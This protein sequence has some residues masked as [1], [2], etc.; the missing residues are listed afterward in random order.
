VDKVLLVERLRVDDRGIDVGEDLEFGCAAD[1]VAVARCAVRDHAPPGELL[2]LRRLER[3]DH[4]LLSRHASDPT[5]RFD[6]HVFWTTMFGN[7][8]LMSRCSSAI[9]TAQRRAMRR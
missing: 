8:E 4:P 5:V 7:L 1:V 6:A 3:L 9:F 2:H